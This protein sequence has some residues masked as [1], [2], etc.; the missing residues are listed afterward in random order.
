MKKP[1]LHV[2]S[3]NAAKVRWDI[4]QKAGLAD[5]SDFGPVG[6]K[7]YD[8]VWSDSSDVGFVLV[9]PITGVEKIFTLSAKRW[10]EEEV[11]C[12]IFVSEDGFTVTV[13]ND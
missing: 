2:P 12:W 7:W 13:F 6:T 11:A 4:P 8:R 10:R 9:S 5:A 1:D 3:H